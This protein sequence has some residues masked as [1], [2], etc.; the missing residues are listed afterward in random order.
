M[1]YRTIFVS[2]PKFLNFTL[3]ATRLPEGYNITEVVK[4]IRGSYRIIPMPFEQNSSL[5]RLIY[6]LWFFCTYSREL[7]VFTG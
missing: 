3:S 6:R 7:N 4:Q 5:G 1:I 2:R